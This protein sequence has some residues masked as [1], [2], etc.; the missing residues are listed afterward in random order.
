[1]FDIHFIELTEIS[2]V[3]LVPP[4][5]FGAS[6]EPVVVV[7]LARVLGSS[8]YLHV[9]QFELWHHCGRPASGFPFKTLFMLTVGRY[10]ASPPSNFLCLFY[11]LRVQVTNYDY[12]Y[13]FGDA[14]VSYT[15]RVV[16][17]LILPRCV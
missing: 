1:M 7:V 10:T 11:K 15:S 12:E 9:T 14:E 8:R 5:S 3:L 17:P 13:V 4:N 6:P 2:W 16:S